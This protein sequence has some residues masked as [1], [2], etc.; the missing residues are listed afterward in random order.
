MFSI[1]LFLVPI[2]FNLTTKLN[3]LVESPMFVLLT[4]NCQIY[5]KTCSPSCFRKLYRLGVTATQNVNR[6]NRCANNVFG[7]I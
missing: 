4:M 5:F 7:Y 6:N 3:I 2:H 1:L